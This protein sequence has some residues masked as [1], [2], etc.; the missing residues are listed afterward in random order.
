MR[1]SSILAAAIVVV[2]V[3]GGILYFWYTRLPEYSLWQARKAF[4]RHDLSSFEKY[5][6]IDSVS[7]SLID[8]MLEVVDSKMDPQDGWVELGKALGKG[9]VTLAKPQLVQF[10]SQ[11]IVSLVEKGRP[12]QQK[13]TGK[14]ASG[15]LSLSGIWRKTGGGQQCRFQGLED[16]R[17]EGSLAFVGMKLLFQKYDAPLVLEL[18][19]RERAGYWQVAGLTNFSDFVRKLDELE[20]RHLAELNK[21]VLEAMRQ[22]LAIEAIEKTTERGSWGFGRKV[23]FN[24][25]LRNTGPK[26]ISEFNAVIVCR[27]PGDKEGSGK[28]IKRIPIADTLRI[29][30]G[31]IANCLWTADVSLLSKADVLLYETPQSGLDIATEINTIRFADSSELKLAQEAEE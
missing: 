26:E 29:L 18:K 23:R 11:E 6:D 1:K 3:A 31:E 19:L 7:G 27:L 13:A 5:V 22:T 9:L 15:G 30:P 12:E 4:E 25:R 8:Q 21:P 2:I 28:E 17:R 24:L 10:T 16:A 20:K 14:P